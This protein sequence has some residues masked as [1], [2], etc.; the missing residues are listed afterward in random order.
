MHV[1][2]CYLC[3]PT[4]YATDK[5]VN[6]NLLYIFASLVLVASV[7]TSPPAGSKSPKLDDGSILFKIVHLHI[8]IPQQYL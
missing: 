1:S 6:M 2:V 7:N 5:A 3:T 4:Y 8:L